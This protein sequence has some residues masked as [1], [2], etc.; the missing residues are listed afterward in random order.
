MQFDVTPMLADVPYFDGI[1]TPF[2][3]TP[4]SFPFPP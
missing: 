2:F 1:A 4:P 3:K